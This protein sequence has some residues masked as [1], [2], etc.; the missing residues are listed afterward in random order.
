MRIDFR[1][2]GPL[3]LSAGGR[4]LPLGSPKQ[5]ALLA[6]LLLHANETVSRDRLI[7]ELW[8]DAAPA[9][10]ASAFHVYLSRLR[11]LLDSAGGGGVLVRQAHGYR[12]RIGPDQLDAERFARLASEGREALAAGDAELAA[13]RFRQALALWR[14]PPLADLE[15]ERF[16]VAASSRLDEE[17]VSALEQR[18]EADLA[19]GRH[20]ELVA[21]LETLV[22]EYP[23]RERL[24]GQLMLALYRSGRQTEALRAYQEA[25]RTLTDELGLEPGHELKELEQAILRQDRT[26]TFQPSV[27]PRTEPEQEP[28]PQPSSVP[29]PREERK[30]VTVLLADPVGFF[31]R[32]EQL[33]PE[34]FR[35]LEDHYWGPLRTQIERHGGTVDRF[36]GDAVV[37]L[38]GAPRAHEDD[39]ERAVRAALAIRD[40]AGEQKGREVRI[41]ITTGEALVRLGAPPHAGEGM[42]A[43]NVIKDAARLEA[44]AS[45]NAILVGESV[46]RATKHLIEYREAE[47]VAA[48]GKAIPTWEALEPRSR[49]GGDDVHEAR[50]PLVG[51]VRELELLLSTLARVRE[52]HSPQLVTLVGVPGIGKSRLVHELMRVVEAEPGI[53]TWRRGRS[54]SYGDGVSFW[55]L[56]EI[57][58]A[59]TGILDS[60]TEEGSGEKLSR[61]VDELLG[62]EAEAQWVE[63]ELRPLVGLAGE[64]ETGVDR[65]KEAF[66][67][68]RRFFEALA[69]RRPLVLVF[70]DLH[71]ADDGLLDFIDALVEWIGGVP[72][73]VLAT[74]RPELLERRPQWAGGKANAATL[75]LSPLPDQE[76]V[77]LL[78]ALL[79]RSLR[80]TETQS[81][82]SHTGGNPLYAVQYARMLSE[83]GDADALPLPGTV[84]A[85]IAARLDALSVEEKSLLQNAA[86]VGRVFW[87]GALASDPEAVRVALHALERKEFVGRESHSA[88]AGEE[89]YVFRHVLL[90]DVAYGQ[91]PRADRADKHL[92]AAEW[93]ESF[94]RREDHAET[95]AHHYL[96]TL[97]YL[98]ALGNDSS[99]IAAPARRALVEAGERASALNAFE[100]AAGYYDQALALWPHDD[101]KRPLV[102]FAF[103]EALHRRGAEGQRERLQQAKEELLAIGDLERAAEAEAMLAE[104]AWFDGND[105]LCL[106][107][108]E[109][110]LGLLHQRPASAARARVLAAVAR[111]RATPIGE[112]EAVV[113]LAREAL[114]IAEALDL[115][116]IR[117][118]A[119][120]TL[121]KARV[122]LADAAGLEDIE[123]GLALA[124]ATNSLIVAERGY[125]ALWIAIAIEATSEFRR[126]PEVYE[127]AIRVAERLGNI[128]LLR[129]AQS[130]MITTQR[131]VGEW[132]DA[133]QAADS[134]IAESERAGTHP[135]G[136]R[137]QRA[138]IRQARDDP[139]G[140]LEDIEKSLEAQKAR[141][142]SSRPHLRS[143]MAV[144]LL[145]ELGRL[146][147]ARTLADEVVDRHPWLG[148]PEFALVAAD[149]GYLS[150]L[151]AALDALSRRRPPDI[152][153][154]AIIEGRFVEAADV[155][156]EMG[157]MTA[158]ARVRLR[159][160]ETLAAQ[161]HRIEANEQLDKALAFYRSV[162]ATRY[163]REAEAL[164]AAT[165]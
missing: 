92:R 11:R 165:A 115:A 132:D 162:G 88:V 57:V 16:A 76:T 28:S 54:L 44:A 86:V 52:E 82:L 37:A 13:D 109:R 72:L 97:Q 136:V 130:A 39:P 23:Y 12:L 118:D 104:A 89:Q 8:G 27:E 35:A 108:L 144:F 2:L 127:E 18:L 6:L 48:K 60:D 153:A 79:E 158:A 107:H 71:W 47:P 111:H 99:R 100:V 117:A 64:S 7:E 66:A 137:L 91:I 114:T 83:R 125:E 5:R 126:L 160:A 55:A 154:E 157:R 42:A 70:E 101:A 131:F 87:G 129:S 85:I 21:E 65:R 50:T 110:A 119:R 155:L 135:H 14:G 45:P 22:T 34:D 56:A 81:L 78:N 30:V 106:P 145:V 146:E 84:H 36:A 32:T 58:K 26:L 139:A 75:S 9:T 77:L 98:R 31:E 24:R 20:R 143:V 147:Q 25:R 121:G 138:Y 69:E 159:A 102:S 116:E 124:V 73:L 128:H 1:I 61:L 4:V 113:E 140:A 152:A 40:W 38:F 151:R 53:V 156:A 161:G 15:S 120:I 68:W 93:L 19:L 51:R 49:S 95:I 63:G 74:A 164:V 46:Y 41:G 163:I 43:G 150:K 94:G 105:E 90:H 133:L 80:P 33:D 149:V 112:W 122:F 59:E 67:A 3:E 103:A 96:S 148:F 29:P 17:R 134:F 10:V 123:Q 142:A 62:D 141:E